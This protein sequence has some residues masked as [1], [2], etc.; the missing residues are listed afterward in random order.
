MYFFDDWQCSNEHVYKERDSMENQK[1]LAK[2]LGTVKLI[3]LLT[4]KPILT[5]NFIILSS[6]QKEL[7]GRLHP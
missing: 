5:C 2:V 6:E 3:D 1:Q 7:N 4:N